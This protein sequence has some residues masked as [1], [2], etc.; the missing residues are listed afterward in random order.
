VISILNAEQNY[1]HAPHF[2]QTLI[3]FKEIIMC[4]KTMIVNAFDIFCV[5]LAILKV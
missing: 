4:F 2:Y 3:E 5:M 1:M